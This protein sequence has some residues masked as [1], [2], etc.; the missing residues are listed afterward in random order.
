MYE[1]GEIE[2]ATPDF[3]HC[4]VCVHVLTSPEVGSPIRVPVLWSPLC[5]LRCV[6]T[7]HVCALQVDEEGLRELGVDLKSLPTKSG[8][9]AVKLSLNVPDRGYYYYRYIAL[10]PFFPDLC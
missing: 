6:L 9:E 3:V 7:P 8:D 1:F 10:L 2:G 5:W 4:K